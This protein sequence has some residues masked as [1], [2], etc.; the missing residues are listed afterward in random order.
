MQRTERIY[1]DGVKGIQYLPKNS[2]FPIF[3]SSVFYSDYHRMIREKNYDVLNNQHDISTQRKIKLMVR[4]YWVWKKT[5]NPFKAFKSV[6]T[7][8]DDGRE[9]ILI[10]TEYSDKGKVVGRT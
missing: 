2:Q 3:L 4:S 1:E 6:S 8:Y 10:N 9:D 7:I 5:Q